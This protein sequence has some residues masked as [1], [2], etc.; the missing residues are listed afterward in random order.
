MMIVP[1]L[2]VGA[3]ATHTADVVVYGGTAAGVMAAV[4]AARMGRSVI[5]VAPELHIGG[6]A[7]E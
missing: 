6:L 1:L 7:V 4:Q 5:L 3:F 2:L